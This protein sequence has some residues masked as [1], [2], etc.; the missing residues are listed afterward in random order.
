MLMPFLT[1]TMTAARV[2]HVY[3]AT[4]LRKLTLK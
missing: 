2:V 4:W 3:A 1:M